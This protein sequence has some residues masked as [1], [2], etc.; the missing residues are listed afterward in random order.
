MLYVCI[1]QYN[2][3]TTMLASPVAYYVGYRVQST[4]FTGI[5]GYSIAVIWL[6]CGVGYGIFLLV[7]SCKERRQL[8]KRPTCHRQCYLHHLLVA[9][10]LTLLAT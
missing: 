8:K 3:Y 5:Y 1:V 9:I 7:T 2:I 6:L 4:A 10:F